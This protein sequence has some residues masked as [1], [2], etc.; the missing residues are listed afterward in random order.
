MTTVT[1]DIAIDDFSLRA[2]T[3]VSGNQNYCFILIVNFASLPHNCM[4][5]PL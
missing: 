3:C 5:K 4:R 1:G 2:G